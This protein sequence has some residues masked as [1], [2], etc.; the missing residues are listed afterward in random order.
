MV[1]VLNEQTS[2]LVYRKGNN[3]SQYGGIGRGKDSP[4]PASRLLP[5]SGQGSDTREI[6]QH[7]QHVA[8]GH[9]RRDGNPFGEVH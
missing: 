3:P 1:R 5:D 7:E 2:Y 8:V 9:E 6:N 4:F